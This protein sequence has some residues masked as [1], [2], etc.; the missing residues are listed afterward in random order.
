M[1][2]IS[3]LLFNMEARAIQANILK[4]PVISLIPNLNRFLRKY[5]L[6]YARKAS[7]VCKDNESVISTCKDLIEGNNSYELGN[8]KNLDKLIFSRETVNSAGRILDEIEKT[9]KKNTKVKKLKMVLL[10]LISSVNSNKE[11]CY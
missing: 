5:D 7:T 9:F 10:C 1:V 4:V 3:K 2:K 6:V 11:L 8:Q